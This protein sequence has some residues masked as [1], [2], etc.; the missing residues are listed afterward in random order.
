MLFFATV[1]WMGYLFNLVEGEVPSGAN[2]TID[3]GEIDLFETW[4][5]PERCA[6]SGIV[7]NDQG[8]PIAGATVFWRAL[9]ML[10][11]HEVDALCGE[12]GALC[13]SF[14]TTK[15]DGSFQLD[16]PANGPFELSASISNV[17]Q[18]SWT[19]LEGARMFFRCPTAPITLQVHGDAEALVSIGVSGQIIDWTPA[20]PMQIILVTGADGNVKWQLYG[21]A[22]L[23]PLTFGVAPAGVMQILPASAPL[24]S[25]DTVIVWTESDG[26]EAFA[27]Y[28]VP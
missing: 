22:I 6:V 15:E 1:E 14:A 5:V 12:D 28:E 7:Q 19:Q 18:T 26:N 9:D 13:T 23:P 20:T 8:G 3:L 25:G 2:A 10:D 27:M 16:Y 17:S 21:E 11:Q 4:A 24:T